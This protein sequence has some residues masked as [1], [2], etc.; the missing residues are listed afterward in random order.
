MILGNHPQD[1]TDY[2]EAWPLHYYEINDIDERE[3]VLLEVLAEHP[4]S[5]DDRRRLEILRK[6]FPDKGRLRGQR[7]DVFMEA[8]MMT[9][10]TG[11]SSINFFNRRFVEKQVRNNL[12]ALMIGT[13]DEDNIVYDPILAAEWS[14]FA[15]R[16]IRACAED[17]NYGSTAFGM[18]HLKDETLL[19]KIA[20]E[21]DEVTHR[22]PLRFHMEKQ[23]RQFRNVVRETFSAITGDANRCRPEES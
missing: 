1:H 23:C 16:L 3:R 18:I 11:R 7:K 5:A 12:S 9:L 17:K 21:I 15:A 19:D 8:W 13:E 20:S 6:R 22:I 10:V 4:D 2:K 14:D